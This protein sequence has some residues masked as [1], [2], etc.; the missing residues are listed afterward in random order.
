MKYWEGF[1]FVH[2]FLQSILIW[3]IVLGVCAPGATAKA[4]SLAAP[5]T[6]PLAPVGALGL[7]GVGRPHTYLILVQN[8][9]ELRPTGGFISAVGRITLDRGRIVDLQFS[10]SY[11]IFQYGVEY[12][13][14]PQ[15]MRDYMAI[16][17][18][19]FRDANWSPDLPTTAEFARAIYRRD[20]GQEFDGL[21]TV[22]LN[23]LRIFVDA[24]GP[25]TA[26]G[27]DAPLTG[28]TVVEQVM[29]LWAH[30]ALDGAGLAEGDLGAWW[31]QRKEFIPRLANAALQKLQS[32]EVSFVALIAAA[33]KA[34]N[35]RAVQVLV[36]EPTV[37]AILAAQGWDGALRPNAEGDFLAVVDMNMG[38]NKVDAVIERAIA[39]TVTWPSGIGHP[40]Q[41]TVSLTYRH[42]LDVVD[43]GCDPA[44]RYGDNYREMMERCYF[45]YV[46]IY[47]PAGSVLLETSGLEAGSVAS[48]RGERGAEVFSGYFIQPP[49]RSHTVRFTYMLPEHIQ[50]GAYNLVLQRQAGT[51]GLPVRLSIDGVSDSFELV[52]GRRR[53]VLQQELSGG[54]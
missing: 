53:Y 6:P 16:P 18:L 36:D 33:L 7:L 26:P 23:A 47:V 30:P 2:R 24:I 22:D 31:S 52:E 8:N 41:A 28:E 17:Y 9:H 38:Y 54:G 43:E 27:I 4:V 25:L 10:D 48:Q 37:A 3:A 5:D 20:T 21:I 49:N 11:D 15:P 50:P 40:A 29:E 14:A 45:D 35:Q 51:E 46:R 39:Y 42:P 32:G 1:A 12:P 13:P 34:L 44:P 19:T